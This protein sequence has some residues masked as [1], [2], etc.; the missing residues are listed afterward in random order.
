MAVGEVGGCCKSYNCVLILV[1]ENQ[2]LVKEKS[3]SFK[4]DLLCEPCVVMSYVDC[5][6]DGYCRT[7]NNKLLG[8]DGCRGSWRLL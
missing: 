7:L 2:I 3:G 8:M 5:G 6:D 1:R 4:V